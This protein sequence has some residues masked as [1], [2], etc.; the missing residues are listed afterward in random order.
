LYLRD[1]LKYMIG[2]QGDF[3]LGTKEAARAMVAVLVA[4]FNACHE[5]GIVIRTVA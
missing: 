3:H 2:L 4:N 1:K 5:R